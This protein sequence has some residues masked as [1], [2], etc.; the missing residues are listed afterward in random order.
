[1]Q[2]PPP[3]S[4]ECVHVDITVVPTAPPPK[5]PTGPSIPPKLLAV[6]MKYKHNWRLDQLALSIPRKQRKKFVPRVEGLIKP[7]VKKPLRLNEELKYYADQ[8]SRP[9]LRYFFLFL[10][11]GKMDLPNVCLQ[12]LVYQQTTIRK[13]YQGT[14]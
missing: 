2:S 12:E 3:P 11:F 6:M 5:P 1:M 7:S 8:V 14:D 13:C 9:K 4:T 10:L